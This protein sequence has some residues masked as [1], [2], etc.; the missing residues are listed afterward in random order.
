M[1]ILWITNIRIGDMAIGKPMG[2][3][4]MDALLKQIK[5]ETEFS[6]VI[7]TSTNANSVE[8]KNVDGIQYYA[9][10]GGLPV[11]Y[12][13][14]AKIAYNEWKEIFDI[15]KPDVI[16]V[17]GTEYSHAIPALEVAKDLKI[18][19]VIYIQGIMKAIS[20]FATGQLPFFTMLRYTTLRDI[21]R[22]QLLVFQNSWFKKRAKTEERL[23]SLSGSVVVE[24]RWAES[25]CKS[26]NP[27]IMVYKIPLNINEEF[28]H[29]NW[30]MSTM[31][32]HTI[33]CNASGPAYKGIHILLEALLLIRSRFPDVKL[34][35]PGKSM[36]VSGGW[37][38]R[39]KVPG[40]WNYVSDFIRENDL[41]E[42]VVFSG[43]L[44]QKELAEKLSQANVFV[45]A[46]SIENH[47]SSLKEAMAVGTPSVASLVG[48]VPEYFHFGDSGFSYR[49][50][51]YE[52]LA[53]YISELF[54]NE[55]LCLKF[56]N[57]SKEKSKGTN[58]I[59]ITKK[60]ISMYKKLNQRD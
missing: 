6:F 11:Y 37:L 50:E 21:Y 4:W 15:E 60:I 55:E 38:S 8:Q 23:I 12:K 1:K 54:E 31:H 33:V 49:F 25:F 45:M 20:R 24:N 47:S 2:G 44:T 58:D 59:E 57:A 36:I 17:W 9:V 52:C 40:Y 3:L 7:A 29:H 28:S 46:S 10:P 39:Q 26:I 19:S 13:R 42:N 35:I 56:S 5:K 32:P 22:S 16:Q 48:G 51:E 27:E 18:P 43:Y 53:G 30:S 41:E 34:F 14:D